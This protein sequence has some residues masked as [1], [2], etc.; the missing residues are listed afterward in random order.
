MLYKME[1]SEHFVVIRDNAKAAKH[2]PLV[3]TGGSEARK[4][5]WKLAADFGP[6][7]KGTFAPLDAQGKLD[8]V[9]LAACYAAH[10][11]CAVPSD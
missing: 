8:L 7:P 3:S 11:A 2:A 6:G 10:Q 4:P 9:L 5:S 1:R